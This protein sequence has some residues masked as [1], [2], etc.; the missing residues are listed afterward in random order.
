MQKI[1]AFI[2]GIIMIFSSGS[3]FAENEIDIVP[4]QQME[5]KNEVTITID[6]EEKMQVIDSVAV[7]ELY[8]K[9][10]KSL[11]QREEWIGGI[12]KRIDLNF[13]VPKVSAGD[14]FALELKSG[15]KYLKYY[16]DVCQ[17]GEKIELTAYSYIDKE[18]KVKIK[19]DFHL[20][21]SPYFEHAIVVYT[22]GYIQNLYPRARLIESTAMIPV[23]PVAKALGIS[24]WYDERYNS[25]VC[26]VGEKQVLFNMGTAYATIFG[27]DTYLSKPCEIIDGTPFVPARALADAFGCSIEPLD[28]GDHI[29]V[30]F[31]ESPIVEEYVTQFPVNEWGISSK[32]GYMVWISKSDYKVRVYTGTKDKWSEIKSFPCAIGAADS[33]TITGSYEYQYRMKQWDYPEYGYY[34]GP[35]LVFYGNYA[36]HSTLLS[37]KGGVYDNRTGVMIS[38]GCVR[39]RPEDIDWLD[40][41]LPIGSRIYITE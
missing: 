10:G 36:I 25:V 34:V 3:A 12:T 17:E 7:F 38:H 21:A 35:C 4:I 8:D 28:F 5:D 31:G 6:L 23:I 32:T 16:D 14:K 29:D 37:Y 24:A 40:K 30:C 15:L 11:G 41:N 2:L 22:E 19:N 39:V 26:E 13:E 20:D 27:E 18:N 1:L 9:D 33:P